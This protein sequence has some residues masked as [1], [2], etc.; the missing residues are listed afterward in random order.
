LH[1]HLRVLGTDSI[2]AAV[3]VGANAVRLQMGRALPDGSIE[4]IH[5]ERDPVRPGQDVFMRG[6]IPS[7]AV[8]RLVATL[9]RYGSLCRR[10]RARVRAVAT[11]ALREARNR[12]EIV[13]RVQREAKLNHLGQGRGATHLPGRPTRQ[14]AQHPIAVRRHRRR[15]D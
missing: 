9:R 12:D 7:P 3:D 5:Q 10:Y 6:A 2:I 13:R 15:L 11:S 4:I 1:N 8:E 14:A